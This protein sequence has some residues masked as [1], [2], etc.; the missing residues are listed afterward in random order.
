MIITGFAAPR[1]VVPAERAAEPAGAAVTWAQAER[2]T[3]A[4]PQL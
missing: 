3:S 4:Q 2:D 1:V